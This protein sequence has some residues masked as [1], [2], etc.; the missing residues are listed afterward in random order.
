MEQLKAE[1]AQSITEVLGALEVVQSCAESIIDAVTEETLVLQGISARLGVGM[2][3]QKTTE[4]EV[5][6]ADHRGNVI[7]FCGCGCRAV[8]R[9]EES[10]R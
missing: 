6:N 8:S 4:N 1:M 7:P 9:R 10:R 3:R 5:K 2:Y